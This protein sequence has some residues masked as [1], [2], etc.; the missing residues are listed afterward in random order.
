MLHSAPDDNDLST[1]CVGIDSHLPGGSAGFRSRYCSYEVYG[2]FASRRL[3]VQR[4]RSWDF[5]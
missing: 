3:G 4:Q 1:F 5:G 2:R